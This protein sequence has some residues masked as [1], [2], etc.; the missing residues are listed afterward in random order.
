MKYYYMDRD[1]IRIR[2][3]IKDIES[4]SSTIIKSTGKLFITCGMRDGSSLTYSTK[5]KYFNLF[6]NTLVRQYEKEKKRH[7]IIL[8][9]EETENILASSHISLYPKDYQSKNATNSKKINYQKY[10][11]KSLSEIIHEQIALLMGIQEINILGL[12]D[13]HGIRDNFSITISTPKMERIIPIKFSKSNEF[14]YHL[15]LGRIYGYHSVN[16]DIDF[17]AQGINVMWEVAGLPIVG[18]TKY[19]VEENSVEKSLE[20][21]YDNRMIFEN[22][23]VIPPTENNKKVYTTND[24]INDNNLFY[25][26]PNGLSISVS[27]SHD[28]KDT[29]RDINYISDN[30]LMCKIRNVYQKSTLVDE[31]T[32]PTV[33]VKRVNEQY[34]LDDIVLS[35]IFFDDI[36]HEGTYYRNQLA[37]HVFYEVHANNKK[38]ALTN[39]EELSCIECLDAH[40][41]KKT[42]E[43]REQ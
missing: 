31:L 12:S 34:K 32:C 5:D 17:D 40:A 9:G 21:H 43:K 11:I 29:I 2:T 39:P 23:E 36:P 28:D 26:L 27:I 19:K 14:S 15:V 10:D 25:V 22:T 38:Y 30:E 20:V 37:I 4:I 1:E 8:L 18:I 24:G 7:T 16:M 42:L 35:Q 41:I 33:S 13:I 6:L 3:E